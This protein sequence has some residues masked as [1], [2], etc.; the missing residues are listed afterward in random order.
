MPSVKISS[1][2][3]C[4]K[5]EMVRLKR[6][7]AIVDL[8]TKINPVNQSLLRKYYDLLGDIKIPLPPDESEELVQDGSVSFAQALW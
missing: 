4:H 6:S 5:A 1:N 2:E 3:G 8:G 7:M